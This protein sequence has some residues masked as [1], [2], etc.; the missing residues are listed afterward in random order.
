MNAGAYGGE[1]K[2]IVTKVKVLCFDGVGEAGTNE[3]EILELTNEEMQFG[4][5][6]SALN[7]TSDLAAV[8][9]VT[10]SKTTR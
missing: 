8:T 10:V 1:M 7:T 2:Q 3:C 6:T 5:R 9:S 4:Y